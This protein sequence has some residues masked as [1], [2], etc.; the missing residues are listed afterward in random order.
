[1]SRIRSKNTIPE[2]KVRKYL[3]NKGYRY[4]INYSLPGKPDIVFPKQK[5]AVFINGCFWHQHSCKNSVIPKTNVKF[6]KNKLEL[7][8]NRDKSIILELKN[9]N[10]KTIILWE[11]EIENNFDNIINNLLNLLQ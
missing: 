4:R 8:K 9:S 2:I 7:N 5:I 6:W 10:W 1:M 3:F 11:C